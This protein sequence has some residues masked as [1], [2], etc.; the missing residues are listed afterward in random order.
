M[1]QSNLDR[2]RS[3]FGVMGVSTRVSI[4]P[5]QNNKVSLSSSPFP[6]TLF[7]V[8][9]MTDGYGGGANAKELNRID[10]F[11]GW[12]GVQA[13]CGCVHAAGGCV[14]AVYGYVLRTCVCVFVCSGRVWVFRPGG[15]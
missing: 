11:C 3:E 1:G 9:R 4:V 8:E 6:S 7:V 14:H 2:L 5:G 10:I 13:V 12:V 15:C